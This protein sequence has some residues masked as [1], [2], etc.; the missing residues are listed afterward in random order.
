MSVSILFGYSVSTIRKFGWLTKKKREEEEKN[1]G[2]WKVEISYWNILKHWSL[3]FWI[4]T[5]IKMKKIIKF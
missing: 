2:S 5:G 1:A 4:L 3:K